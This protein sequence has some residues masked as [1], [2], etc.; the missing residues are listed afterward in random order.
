MNDFETHILKLD[1]Q[2]GLVSAPLDTANRA[3][4]FGDGVFETMIFTGGKIRFMA[5]H[6]ARLEEGLHTLKIQASPL[7]I[8]AIEAYLREHFS[9]KQNLRVRWNVYRSG[10][11][12]YTPNQNAAENL[13]IIQPMEAPAAIKK[14]AYVSRELSVPTTVWSH[15]K[16]LNALTY[17]MAN[18]ERKELGMDEVILLSDK[19]FVAEAGTANIFWRKDNTYYT[20]SLAC[21][22]I[23]GVGRRK[24]IEQ[25]QRK[26]LPLVEGQFGLEEVLEA[27][28]VFTSNVTG[29]VYIAQL[30]G[31]NFCTDPIPQVTEIFK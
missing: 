18:I 29:V 26:G 14:N 11:G 10:L 27:E 4:F 2:E 5:E 31:K 17:V 16:T 30:E 24:I 1:V 13:L 15:C 25:L 12:K 3:S 19:G 21:N 22:C 20:P 7:S 6:A 9:A 23:A 8:P 28:Q